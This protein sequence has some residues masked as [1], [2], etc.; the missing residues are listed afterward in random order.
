MRV[1]VQQAPHPDHRLA[2]EL[3]LRAAAIAMAVL[4]ILGLLPEI[5]RAAG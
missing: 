4:L 5:A 3:L 1:I 2:R